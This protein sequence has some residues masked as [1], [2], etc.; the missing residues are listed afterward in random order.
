[1]RHYKAVGL[2]LSIVL[3]IG[4]WAGPAALAEEKPQYGGS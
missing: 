3:V 1:M 4:L 2:V